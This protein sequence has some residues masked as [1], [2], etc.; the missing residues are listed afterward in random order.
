MRADNDGEGGILA[1]MELV[2]PA[3]KNIKYFIIISLGLFG[4]SLLYGD[5]IITP[6]I[7]VLS[8]VEGL[9]LATP[10]FEPYVIPLT[11]I[12]LFGLFFFQHRGTQGIGNIF[13][14]V[15]VIWFSLIA[16]LCKRNPWHLPCHAPG[17]YHSAT[18][19]S[20]QA[21]TSFGGAG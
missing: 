3:K 2:R 18:A 11:L 1:L 15:M 19:E 17:G 7:S 21:A 9:N 4:A 6:A 13:G 12:I 5:G 14:P 16:A 8:A 10:F 20:F